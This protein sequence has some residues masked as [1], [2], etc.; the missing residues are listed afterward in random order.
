MEALQANWNVAC[1]TEHEVE[2]RVFTDEFG[3]VSRMDELPESA[4][5][6]DVHK[7]IIDT[8]VQETRL[9][10]SSSDLVESGRYSNAPAHQ[11][12][13]DFIQ[14]L[15]SLQRQN[16]AE[17]LQEERDGAIHDVLAVLSWWVDCHDVGFTYRG[18]DMPVDLSGMGMHG[19]YVGRRDGWE[20]P[21]DE[22]G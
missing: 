18:E 9:S 15:S 16:L 7:R 4:T 19:D 2:H 6:V 13:N 8:L 14:S 22:E 1:D 12:F 5:V 21:S 17:L 10:A 3:S 11:R 20:W